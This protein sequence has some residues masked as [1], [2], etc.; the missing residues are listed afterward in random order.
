MRFGKPR[1]DTG[2]VPMM[3]DDGLGIHP[4]LAKKLKARAQGPG[5]PEAGT[6]PPVGELSEEPADAP[7]VSPTIE[8]SPSLVDEGAGEAPRDTNP[9]GPAQGQQRTR[10]LGPPPKKKLAEEQELAELPPIPGYRYT[11]IVGKGAMGRVYRAIK[12]DDNGDVAIK[13]LAPELAVRDDFIARFEREAAALRA[14]AHDGV[15][16]VTD[17]GAVEDLHYFVM[18]FIEGKSLR[19]LVAKGPLSPARALGFSRQIAQALA[20]AHRRKVIH[21]DLKPENIIVASPEPGRERLVLVDFGLAGMGEDDPHPNLTKSRMTMGTV[22]Y[23]APEQ[24][25]DAKRVGPQ[26]DLYALGVILYELLTGDLPLGRFKLPTERPELENL[27][28]RIDE[29]ISKAL[30]RDPEKRYATAGAFDKDLAFIEA[31]LLRASSRD[32]LVGHDSGLEGPPTEVQSAPQFAAKSQPHPAAPDESKGPLDESFFSEGPVPTDGLPLYRRPALLWGG[33]ALVIG[34]ALG[35]YG[36][37]REDDPRV[38]HASADEMFGPAVQ[39][40]RT[41]SGTFRARTPGW[42]ASGDT[43]SYAPRPG[44][45]HGNL[46]ML[47]QPSAPPGSTVSGHAMV[48]AGATDAM[49]GFARG[50]QLIAFGKD[51]GRC[52]YLMMGA[53]GAVQ[54]T[55]DAP[56]PEGGGTM[57]LR[58]TCG[59]AEGGVVCQGSFGDVDAKKQVLSDVPFAAW[60]YFVGCR[61]DKA[62]RFEHA[63]SQ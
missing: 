35:I 34:A 4:A 28:K 1:K 32:T 57:S 41:T 59:E 13:V 45:A 30:D 55:V 36:A 11:G 10:A 9:L 61:R 33:L 23:M 21:R 47:S 3:D 14:V 19:R 18:P 43:V 63:G 8:L 51:E 5:T 49:V 7:Q 27:P 26:A 40:L 60:S 39:T 56:C 58:L 37:Q 22:N 42:N 50:G 25:T 2:P 29:C 54:K 6:P 38:L 44:A 46:A 62:C 12:L 31:E 20:A 53:Q 48:D 52:R 24:R 15:V 16:S 17:R